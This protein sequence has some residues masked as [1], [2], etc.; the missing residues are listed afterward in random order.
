MNDAEFK[1]LISD[2]KVLN[3][4]DLRIQRWRGSVDRIMELYHWNREKAAD[5]VVRRI[6]ED[7]KKGI[8]SDKS[9]EK[10]VKDVESDEFGQSMS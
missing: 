4:E 7:R 10:L 5:L 1:R 3:S 2:T 9:L 8:S 6:E